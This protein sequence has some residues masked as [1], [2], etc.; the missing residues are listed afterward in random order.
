MVY[1]PS[2][3][4]APWIVNALKSDDETTISKV[5]RLKY[6]K[7]KGR[8]KEDQYTFEFEIGVIKEGYAVIDSSVLG[9]DYTLAIETYEPLTIKHFKAVRDISIFKRLNALK[10]ESLFIGG[11]HPDAIPVEIYRDLIKRFPT[12]TEVTKYAEARIFA[13]LRNYIDTGEDPERNYE[14]YLV[15]RRGRKKSKP[16]REIN[17]PVIF[18]K[19]ETQKYD[20]LYSKLEDMLAHSEEYDED[21]WQAEILHIILLLFPRYI[22]AIREGKVKDTDTGGIKEVDFLLIDASGFIDVVEIKKPMENSLVTV[23][24]VG[25]ANHVPVRPFSSAVMQVEK[26]LYH[27]NRSGVKGE[28]F[29]QE[30]YGD[31]LHEGVKI[32]IVNPQGFIIMGIELGLSPTQIKDFEVIKRQYK[33]VLDIITY[34]DLLRRLRTIRDHFSRQIEE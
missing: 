11:D 6:D 4:E 17:P 12:S 25:K 30:E 2:E 23:N 33:N 9:I 18:A 21:E 1:N 10:I 8:L 34:D 7:L 20:D 28:A 24:K 31:E 19:Y 5:F 15:T 26:Y 14:D 22:K 32:K 13:I 3:G 16:P 27:F 29:L